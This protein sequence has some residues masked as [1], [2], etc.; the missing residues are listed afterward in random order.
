MCAFNVRLSYISRRRNLLGVA[1][2]GVVAETLAFHSQFP[3]GLL[4]IILYK[5]NKGDG[6]Q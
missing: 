5:L 3:S 1:L 6:R 2:T 4:T